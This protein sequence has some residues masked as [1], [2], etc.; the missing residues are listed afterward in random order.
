MG[1]RAGRR[2]HP[3]S[4]AAAYSASRP[5]ASIAQR[6]VVEEAARQHRM[7]GPRQHG[8]GEVVRVAAARR[9][10]GDQA[11]GGVEGFGDHSAAGASPCPGIGSARGAFDGPSQHSLEPVSQRSELSGCSGQPRSDL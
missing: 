8:R 6:A 9:D 7:R 2:L 5:N 10:R 11:I 3:A 4:T 1:H